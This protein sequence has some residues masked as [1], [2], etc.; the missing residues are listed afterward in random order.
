[1]GKLRWFFT[2]VVLGILILSTTFALLLFFIILNKELIIDD[3]SVDWFDMLIKSSFTLLGST[4]SGFVAILVF[5]LNYLREKRKEKNKSER[6]L[7]LIAKDF[8]AN[9]IMLDKISEI[10][11]SELTDNIAD[12]LMHDKNEV[13]ELFV[14]TS[15]KIAGGLFEDN[16]QDLQDEDHI[17]II[18]PLTI[19]KSCKSTLNLIVSGINS[20]ENLKLLIDQF[21]IELILLQNLEGIQIEK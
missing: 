3:S 12:Y 16:V 10:I 17:K 14:I 9:K 4:L 20:K 19:M 15:T 6:L 18:E 2:S 21:K 11:N 8:N 1:M 13:L 7:K 5:Y